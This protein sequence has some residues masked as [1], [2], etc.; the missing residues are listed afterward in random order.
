MKNLSFKICLV[1]AALFGSVGG[2]FANSHLPN[3]PGSP[4]SVTTYKEIFN[5]HNCVGTVNYSTG[6]KYT[7]EFKNNARWGEDIMKIHKVRDYE[8]IWKND[9]FQYAQKTPYS[10]RTAKPSVL[11]TA[12][13][14]LSKEKRK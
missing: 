11:R 13:V 14:K 8:G 2:G 4:I 5:W 3:C 12:F 1:I 7:D 9:I 6:A 10:K